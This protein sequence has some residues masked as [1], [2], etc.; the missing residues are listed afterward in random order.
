M[1]NMEDLAVLVGGQP[2][3]KAA[4]NTL[5]GVKFENLGQAR[6]AWANRYH[7]GVVGGKGDPRALRTYIGN[8]RAAHAQAKTPDARKEIQKRIGKL[9]GGS[10]TLWV[11]GASDLEI[12]ARKELAERTA[13]AV[14]S[15]VREGVVPGGGVS[16]LACRTPLQEKLKTCTDTDEQA[17][18]RILIKAMEAPIRTILA[19]GGYDPSEV[20]A[21]IRLA[22][23]G[24]GFDARSGRIIQMAE[25]GIWD[26]VAVLKTAAHSAIVS[27]GLALTTDVLVHHK[28]RQQV[29]QP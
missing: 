1:T 8:L 14:R 4:G 17:A 6:R 2:L 10:A 13:D 24:F 11:G 20:M 25:A 5:D 27:A 23:D 9:M 18:F 12:Q 3:V 26:S 19:N 21:E 7:L 22:G 16:F 29:M 28:K 15:A